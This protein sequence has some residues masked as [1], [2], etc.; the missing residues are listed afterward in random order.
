MWRPLLLHP[1]PPLPCGHRPRHLLG[2][3]R[4]WPVETLQGPLPRPHVARRAHCRHSVQHRQD[5]G[6][7]LLAET[8]ASYNDSFYIS[9]KLSARRSRVSK[10]SERCFQDVYAC[11]ECQ[12]NGCQRFCKESVIVV[13]KFYSHIQQVKYTYVNGYFNIFHLAYNSCSFWSTL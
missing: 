3:P 4:T 7:L 12:R 10:R 8:K 13:D 11:K 5:T 2:H 6:D 9:H 1:G